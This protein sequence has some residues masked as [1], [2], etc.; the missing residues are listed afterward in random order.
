MKISQ[1]EFD[2]WRSLPITEEV[3]REVKSRREEVKEELAQG[4]HFHS[5]SADETLAETAKLIG[6]CLGLDDLLNIQFG[7][8]GE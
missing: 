5:E 1:E 4:L 8:G 2:S 3:F 7:E 6:Y